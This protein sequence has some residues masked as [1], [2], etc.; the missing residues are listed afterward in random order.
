MVIA[1]RT[2]REAGLSRTLRDH[3]DSADMKHW[4]MSLKVKSAGLTPR[5]RCLMSGPAI[6]TEMGYPRDVRFSPVSDH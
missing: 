1:N 2:A 4:P 6:A 5:A 3:K